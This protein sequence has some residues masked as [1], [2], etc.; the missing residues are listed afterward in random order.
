[1]H[2]TRVV[3]DVPHLIQ[4]PVCERCLESH[5]LNVFGEV[6]I[7]FDRASSAEH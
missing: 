7:L 5:D 1:M 6:I 3:L 2:R 4:H